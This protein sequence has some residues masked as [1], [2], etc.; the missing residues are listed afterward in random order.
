MLPTGLGKPVTDTIQ[1]HAGTPWGSVYTNPVTGATKEGSVS[2]IDIKNGTKTKELMVGL[3]PNA[4]V[5]SADEHFL[6]VANSNSDNISVIDVK[7][8]QVIDSIQVGLFSDQNHYC[9]SSPNGLCLHPNGAELFVA[10]GLDNAIAVIKLGSNISAKGI[11]KTMVQGYFPTE[12]YPSGIAFVNNHLYITNLEAKGAG[13]LSEA[14]E[15][16]Q[17]NSKPVSAFSIHKQLASVSV[18]PAPAPSQLNA[19]TQK[20]KLLNLSYRLVALLQQTPR[21]QCKT[22]A[23]SGADW[24]AFFV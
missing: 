10:N 18:I 22:K 7:K 11:G 4:I 8:E 21:K 24:R 2:I 23:C 9:G 15:L 3:H 13:V 1:E 6:Y 5:K 16:K 17:P 12:A 19:Y 14:H 20:V